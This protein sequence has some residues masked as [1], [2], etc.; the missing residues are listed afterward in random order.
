[1]VLGEI[2]TSFS[3]VLPRILTPSSAYNLPPLTSCYL[4]SLPT[5][6]RD[7]SHEDE[8]DDDHDNNNNDDDDNDGGGDDDDN[9]GDHVPQ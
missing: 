3:L 4:P 6:I 1:M 9:G 8:E 2:I 5:Q 7:M